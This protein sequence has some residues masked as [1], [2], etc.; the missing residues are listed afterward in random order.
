MA[1]DYD[2]IDE[3]RSVGLEILIVQED[4][5]APRKPNEAC[6]NSTSDEGDSSEYEADETSCFTSER[7]SKPSFLL[8]KKMRKKV[9]HFQLCH[10]Y[11]WL[12]QEQYCSLLQPQ[13]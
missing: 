3:E 10:Q 1:A 7:P 8:G 11:L 9:R 6:D 13:V 4:Y 2:G 5:H 12:Y